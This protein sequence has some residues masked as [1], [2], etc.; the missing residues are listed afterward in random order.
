MRL[1]Y[2]RVGKTSVDSLWNL[3]IIGVPRFSHASQNDGK[4]EEV[5]RTMHVALRQDRSGGQFWAHREESILLL[6][7][8]QGQAE[9][10]GRPTSPG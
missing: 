9:Q 1:N 2:C 6:G 5:A 7:D 4:D 10:K 3:Y 8:Q